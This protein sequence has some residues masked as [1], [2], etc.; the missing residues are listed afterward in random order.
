MN[1][2]MNMEYVKITPAMAKQLLG[3]TENNRKLSEATVRAYAN[4]MMQGNWDENTSASIAIDTDGILRDGQ[5]RMAAI[6]KSGKPIKM[7]VCRMVDADGLYDIGRSRS[8]ADQITIK[9]PDF[10]TFYKS[11]QAQAVIRFFIQ[12]NHKRKVTFSEVKDFIIKHHDVLTPFFEGIVQT[13]Y[14]KISVATVRI[15]MLTAYCAGVPLEDL[16]HFYEVLGTGMSD[17]E[18]E[19]PIIAYRNYLISLESHPTTTIDD[20]KR[21]QYAI[22]KYMTNSKTKRSIVPEKEVYPIYPIVLDG[23]EPEV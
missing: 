23:T 5:H 3:T 20:V 21:C 10:E 18:R 7:W 22:Y 2:K 9:C 11:S 1:T 13:T 8:I 14:A 12:K 6:V 19:F 17:N 15:S 4:D 16:S